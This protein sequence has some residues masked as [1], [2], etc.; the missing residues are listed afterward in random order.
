MQRFYR[1]DSPYTYFTTARP[2]LGEISL[3]CSRSGASAAALWLTL[4]LFPLTRQGLGRVLAAGRRAALRWTELIDASPLL[5][6]YQ[7]PELDI[8]TYH[9][10]LT[11]ARLSRIGAASKE[12]MRRGMQS[13]TQDPVFLSTARIG[14]AAFTARRPDA[15]VDVDSTAVLRSVLMKP[16]AEP[17][18][19]QLHQRV[20]TLTAAVVGE[21]PAAGA[22]AHG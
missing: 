5:D 20:E 9:P 21:R 14:G 18:L 2:H 16:E 15:V 12:V 1:H 3:E 11:P 17:Y 19:D 8:V 13:G 6:L 10:R 7:R 22:H 4:K